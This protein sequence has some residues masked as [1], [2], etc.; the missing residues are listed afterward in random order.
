MAIDSGTAIVLAYVLTDIGVIIAF[1]LAVFG[2]ALFVNWLRARRG[3][4]RSDKRLA[5]TR[6][7]EEIVQ[8]RKPSHHWPGFLR[9]PP[10]KSPLFREEPLPR[11]MVAPAEPAFDAPMRDVMKTLLIALGLTAIRPLPDQKSAALVLV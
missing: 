8:K 3:G 9:R 11:P 6:R 10:G 1:L 2:I 4:Q 7:I 5:S